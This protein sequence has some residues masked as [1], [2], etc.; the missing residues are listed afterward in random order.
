MSIHDLTH[1]FP[2][3]KHDARA[4]G[5]PPYRITGP[6]NKDHADHLVDD[7]LNDDKTRQAFY[8][9]MTGAVEPRE[10][11]YKLQKLIDNWHEFR[12]SP[13]EAS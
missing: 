9:F 12:T 2:S 5:E 13:P 8:A 4:I 10:F 1:K 6:F 7:V 11:V 3:A